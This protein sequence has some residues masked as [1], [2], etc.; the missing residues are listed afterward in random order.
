MNVYQNMNAYDLKEMSNWKVERSADGYYT[1]VCKLEWAGRFVYFGAKSKKVF[2]KKVSKY[3]N[4]QIRNQETVAYCTR[5]TDANGERIFKT[6][7][8]LSTQ[9][10]DWNI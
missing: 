8:E 2:L 4:H 9:I 10:L 6:Q 1:A 3:V 7:P 5:E